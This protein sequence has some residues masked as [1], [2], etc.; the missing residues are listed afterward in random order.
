[1]VDLGNVFLV[2]FAFPAGVAGYWA[3]RVMTYWADN[4][5]F[6]WS[7]IIGGLVGGV[8]AAFFSWIVVAVPSPASLILP[9][10]APFAVLGCGMAAG[11]W[12]TRNDGG[13]R[14]RGSR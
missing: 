9:F 13:W 4:A 5:L 8:C 14:T 10:S 7:I 12:Q 11:A 1:M 6:T 3:A 2:L